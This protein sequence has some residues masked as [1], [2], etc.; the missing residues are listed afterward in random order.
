MALALAGVAVLTA[1]AAI[2][3]AWTRPTAPPPAVARFTLAPPDGTTFTVTGPNAPHLAVS[4]NGRYVA[5]IADDTRRQRTI[6]VRALDSLS[7]QRLDRT[8]GAM[9][10]FWSPDSQHIAYFA[11]GKLMRISVAGGAPVTICD[12]PAGE[13]GAWF[14]SE[15]QDGIIVFAPTT[16]GPLQRVLAQGGVPTAATTLAT[17]RPGT[18][19]HSSCPTDASCTWRV[20]T[21]Q[22]SMF[23]PQERSV[24][25]W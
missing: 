5:F 6:W 24:R 3:W 7:A 1:V 22:R 11:D 13:G 8:D 10:P 23:S 9:F 21:S 4:P 18:H 14:Q 25:S 2:G 16:D 17:E 12:A 19:S 20:G 15:G